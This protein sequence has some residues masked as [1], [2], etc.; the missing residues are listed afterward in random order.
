MVK[1]NSIECMDCLEYL[2]QIPDNFVDLVVTDPPYNVSQKN[3]IMFNGRKIR[4]NFGE[5]DH[6]F[7]PL[8]VLKELKRVLKPNGQI[9]VFCATKQIPQYMGTF[10]KDWQFR[11]LIVWYKTNPAPRLSKTNWVFANEYILYAINE[12]IPPGKATFNF[13]GQVAMHNTIVS[14]ALQGKERLKNAQ[15]QALHPTQKP[16]AILKKLI[17]ISSNPGD[18]V[19]DPFMGVGSTAVACKELG[20]NYLG[21]ELDTKYTESIIIRLNSLV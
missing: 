17:E 20:R 11:N 3:D 6:G 9:Y 2:K 18:I 4:K 10:Q 7:D 19:L 15:N 16:L 5:W 21:C 13:P 12:K 14:G 1:L 8:P